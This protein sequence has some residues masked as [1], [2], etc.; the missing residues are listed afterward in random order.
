MKHRFLKTSPNLKVLQPTHQLQQHNLTSIFGATPAICS[1]NKKKNLST[2]PNK[3]VQSAFPML[4]KGKGALADD[5]P[6]GS[7]W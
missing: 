5:V 2:L 6:V 7:A 1:G 4:S 3:N